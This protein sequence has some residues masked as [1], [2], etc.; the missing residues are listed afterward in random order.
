M[1]IVWALLGVALATASQSQPATTSTD[2]GKLGPQA[3]QRVPD[4]SLPDQNG[5]TRTLES[6]LGSGGAML[7]FFRS[8]DW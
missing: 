4:F 8:A 1:R 3:G 6:I 5:T 2:F 7:V